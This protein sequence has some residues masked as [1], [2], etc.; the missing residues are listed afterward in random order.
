MA[1]V[2]KKNRFAL[3]AVLTVT[4]FIL[5]YIIHA[6]V[7]VSIKGKSLVHYTD[8]FFTSISKGSVYFIPE[9]IKKSDNYIARALDVKIKGDEKAALIFTKAGAKVDLK[10]GQL[11]IKG[12][13]GKILKN[14][15]EDADTAFKGLDKILYDQYGYAG[16]EIIQCW[17]LAFKEIEAAYKKA[18]Q[19]EE[20]EFMAAV[21]I[22]A[23]EPAFN[24]YGVE[25]ASASKRVLGIS[26]VIGFYVIYTVWWGFAIYFLCEGVGLLMTKSKQKKEA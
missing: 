14:T 10:N 1:V 13:L 4:F 2:V 8:E 6:P 5:L 7:V 23:L 3:G 11:T 18:G 25:A 19:A 15:L 26:G 20:M 12:D 17:W 9:L 24:F 22:K 16:K 21:R